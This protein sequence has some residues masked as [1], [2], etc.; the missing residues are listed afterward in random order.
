M[1]DKYSKDNLKNRNISDHLANERTFLAWIRTAIALMGFG[2]VIVKFVVFLK[3]FALIS[4]NMDAVSSHMITRSAVVGISMVAFGSF[5]AFFG[6]MRYKS[7]EQKINNESYL[8]TRW[9]SLLVMLGVILV[10]ALMV[11][12]LIPN[13]RN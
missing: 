13:I 7:V 11:Y 6:Y 9:L 12:Y 2:F 3:Q 4:G 8:H 1:T 5:I 10:G